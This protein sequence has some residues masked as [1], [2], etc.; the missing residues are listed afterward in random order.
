[1]S[2]YTKLGIRIFKIFASTCM[3]LA[4]ISC[5]HGT[6]LRD[7]RDL[8][9]SAISPQMSMLFEVS[10]RDKSCKNTSL[11]FEVILS[12]TNL[13]NKT[14]KLADQFLLSKNRYGFGGNITPIITFNG[15]DIYTLQDN[16]MMDIPIPDVDN[17]IEITPY[18]VLT[19]PIQYY[20]PSEILNS[21]SNNQ[22]ILITPNSGIYLIKFIFVQIEQES[23]SWHGAL[24]SNP[25][26]ICIK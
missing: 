9:Q 2:I 4:P 13:E 14:I 10:L 21:K 23:G 1:M 18:G 16:S 22:E 11:P 15:E 3:V 19:K 8:T 7:D 6:T 25:L 24:Q 12:F 5:S 17:Y 20:F 26:E